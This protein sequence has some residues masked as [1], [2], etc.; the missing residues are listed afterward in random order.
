MR[1]NSINIIISEDEE[2]DKVDWIKRMW[3]SIP[4]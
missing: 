1:K 4:I 2:L 3:A